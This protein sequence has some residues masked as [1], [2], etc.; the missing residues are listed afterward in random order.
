MK[1]L[2]NKNGKK[3]AKASFFSWKLHQ[4]KEKNFVMIREGEERRIYIMGYIEELRKVVGTRPL[5]LVGSAIIILNDNQEVLLQ[6][7]SDTYDWGVPGGAMELGETTEETARREL[8]EETGLT[9][10]IMQFLGVLSG[11]EVYFR[12]PN[13]DEIFNVIH[14]YQ[15]HHV[16]GELRLDH[17]G[18]KLQYFPV[19]KLPKLN[20]TTEKISQKFLYALT[21]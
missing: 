9:A 5:I 4:Q 8:L 7:R 11:K 14:L 1:V 18:L 16:S 6:Y 3:E 21:E 17:E 19:D 10:K 15:G 12:Y 20:E 2:R 13:G